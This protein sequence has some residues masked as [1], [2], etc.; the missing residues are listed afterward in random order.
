MKSLNVLLIIADALRPDHMGCYGY[1]RD[2]TPFMDS[3]AREGILFKNCISNCNHTMPGLITIF[4]GVYQVVHGID[5]QKSFEIWNDSWI[6]GKSPFALMQESGYV[7]TGPDPNIYGRVGYAREVKDVITSIEELR[8]E[9]FFIWYRPETTH[10]PYNPA[11]P[12][13]TMFFPKGYNMSDETKKRLEVVK[14][15]LLVH[16]PGLISKVESGSKDAIEKPGYQRTVGITHL[17][18]EDRPGLVA[19]Y[20]GEV[21]TLD[22]EIRNYVLKLE[23]LG[24]K[25]NTLI[26]I[27]SDHGEQL[28]ERG[29]VGHSSCSLEGNLFD[30]NIKI[31]FIIWCPSTLPEGKALDT[32]VSQVDIMPTLLDILKLEIPSWIDGKSLLPLIKKNSQEYDEKA[33]AMTQV[34]GWQMLDND[35][36]MV[37]CIRMPEK[38]LIY[39]YDPKSN[40]NRYELY[41][42]IN[43]PHEKINIFNS[44]DEKTLELKL[45]LYNWI[46][47]SRY[48]EDYNDMLDR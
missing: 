17:Y 47:K 43:D 38:K 45:Q 18:D 24:L 28:L 48:R 20:D 27:T 12:Y 37:W 36:R 19:L 11:P 6:R 42:L 22:D 2:T 41:D 26:I 44:N 34:C 39:Y 13:D 40:G 9:K 8:N 23:E 3:L 35:D 4:T 46:K 16:K 21:R 15:S 29:A 32:Q 14:S 5:S 31:P 1:S 25:D 30:E 33:Y 7:I 10:L